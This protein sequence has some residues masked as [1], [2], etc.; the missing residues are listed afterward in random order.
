M[1]HDPVFATLLQELGKFQAKVEFL[2]QRIATLEGRVYSDGGDDGDDVP[3]EL[4]IPG[5]GKFSP[6]DLLARAMGMSGTKPVP[7]PAPPGA[8]SPPMNGANGGVTPTGT[9]G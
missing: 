7:T 2:E 9:G 8:S 6:K 1:A 3:D 4:E 5:L